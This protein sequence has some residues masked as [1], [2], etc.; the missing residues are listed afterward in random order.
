M[1]GLNQVPQ[2][3]QASCIVPISVASCLKLVLLFVLVC[4][5]TVLDHQC[6]R[7]HQC[8]RFVDVE[9]AIFTHVAWWL[10]GWWCSVAVHTC[11]QKDTRRDRRRALRVVIGFVRWAFHRFFVVG[12]FS[13]LPSVGLREAMI[14]LVKMHVRSSKVTNE[15]YVISGW[16]R[17]K[18]SRN[19][20]SVLYYGTKG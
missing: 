20:R 3:Q 4:V 9:R 12:M 6:L 8:E 19:R 17:T 2:G 10:R 18:C 11:G 5:A 14:L 13:M 15:G 7:V 1:L 16:D